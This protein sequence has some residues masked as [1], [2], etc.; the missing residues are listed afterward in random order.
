MILV[1]SELPEV[2]GIADRIVVMHKGRMVRVIE[3]ADFDAPAIVR[4]AIGSGASSTE[5]VYAELASAS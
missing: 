5:N 1:S 4:A 3:R 2:M